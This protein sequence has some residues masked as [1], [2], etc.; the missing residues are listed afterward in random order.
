MNE[1]RVEASVG[2]SRKIADFAHSFTLDFAPAVVIE[3]RRL[4][5]STVWVFRSWH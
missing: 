3:T 5:S 4:R 1:M 2:L